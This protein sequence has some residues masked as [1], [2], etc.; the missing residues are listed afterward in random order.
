M[1]LPVGVLRL[2]FHHVVAGDPEPMITTHYFTAGAGVV[3]GPSAASAALYAYGA[4]ANAFKDQL[5]TGLAMG[6]V[7]WQA[8]LSAGQLMSGTSALT[9]QV[10]G[11]N[12]ATFLPQ[13][14]AYL[15]HRRSF[16]GG[17]RGSGRFYLPYIDEGV[18]DNVGNLT[19]LRVGAMT[20]RFDTFVN[21]ALAPGAGTDLVA[22]GVVSMA[23][24]TNPGTFVETPSRYCDPVI[25]TQRRR[26]RR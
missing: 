2:G 23:T 16:L 6:R 5:P 26:L 4:Y 15:M 1:P 8:Q 18:V 20:T 10:N 7:D 19:S 25:A 9:P 11:T 12:P 22:Y 17:R 21:N 24:P 13:N 3:D 14:C